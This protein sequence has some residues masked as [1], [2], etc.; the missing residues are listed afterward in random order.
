LHVGAR[1]RLHPDRGRRR[2]PP[3]PRRAQPELRLR[4]RA[5]R[6]L[7]RVRVPARVHGVRRARSARAHVAGSPRRQSAR[8]GG[9]VG[10]LLAPPSAARDLAV[11]GA[12]LSVGVATNATAPLR[13][14][15]VGMR[16]ATLMGVDSLFV[17]DHYLS[18]VPRSVWGP[19]LTPAAK[20]VPS[21]DACSD[22]FVLMAMM[23]ARYRRVRIGTSVTA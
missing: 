16:I 3:R 11:V 12:T 15:Q 7:L 21:P 4:H 17:P 2:A 5:V 22:P 9:D 14:E 23:A 6:G 10:R 8:S 1:A 13:L 18:F 19:G 20:L